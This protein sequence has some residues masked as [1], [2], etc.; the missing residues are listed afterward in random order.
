MTVS[1]HLNTTLSYDAQGRLSTIRTIDGVVITNSYDGA[2]QVRQ[3]VSGP[4]EHA[5]NRTYIIS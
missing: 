1:S 2:L 4:F 5:I 3:S